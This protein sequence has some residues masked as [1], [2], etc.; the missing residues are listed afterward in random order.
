MLLSEP[1]AYQNDTRHYSVFYSALGPTPNW[2]VLRTAYY[3]PEK[4]GSIAYSIEY[5]TMVREK[6]QCVVISFDVI[7]M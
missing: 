3:H 4:S 5:S 6:K 1:S 7:N 2:V